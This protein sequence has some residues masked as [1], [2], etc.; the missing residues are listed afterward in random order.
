MFVEKTV[1]SGSIRELAATTNLQ[2]RDKA[3]V[4]TIKPRDQETPIK[5]CTL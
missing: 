2:S 3:S 4:E 5:F 1:T